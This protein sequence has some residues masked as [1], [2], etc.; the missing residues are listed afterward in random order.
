MTIVSNLNMADVYY[1]AQVDNLHEY[2]ERRGL[3]K[4]LS[5][6]I[7]EFYDFKRHHSGVFFN[8]REIL[9][10]LPHSLRAEVVVHISED[11]SQKVSKIPL[12]SGIEPRFMDNI[13]VR[14]KY[15]P[16]PPSETVVM[17]GEVGTRMYFINKGMLQV[18]KKL[19]SSCGKLDFYDSCCAQHGFLTVQCFLTG[20]SLRPL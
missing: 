8:E 18:I 20:S 15:I 11:I 3:P 12:F 10:D 1:H 6:R 14:M 5:H 4:S 2:I 16:Y 7:L 13:M 9:K 17:E 19:Q